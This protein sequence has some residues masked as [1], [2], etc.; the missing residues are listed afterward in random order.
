MAEASV[1]PEASVA[2]PGLGI[3]TIG[4][5]VYAYSGLFTATTSYQDVLSF[6]SPAGYIV[7][8]LQLNSGIDAA[9]PG[10]RVTNAA[11]IIFN[12]ITIA[13]L[14]AGTNTDDSP[15][16]E[17]Q[18]LLIPPLTIVTVEVDSSASSDRQ[19]SV[20]FIGRVYGAE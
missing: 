10:N 17:T 4:C 7:G 15:T 11:N 3:R 12:G 2:S 16:S 8:I 19:F 9:A 18:D 5:H 6:Q 20:T 14:A 13:R 1:T